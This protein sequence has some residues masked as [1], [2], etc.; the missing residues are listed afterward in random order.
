[1]KQDGEVSKDDKD[2]IK[3]GTSLNTQSH[4][5]GRLQWEKWLDRTAY[6]TQHHMVRPN[7]TSPPHTHTNSHAVSEWCPFLVMSV[8]GNEKWNYC[9]IIGRHRIILQIQITKMLKNKQRWSLYSCIVMSQ[10][11]KLAVVGFSVDSSVVRTAAGHPVTFSGFWHFEHFI[12]SHF[13][14]AG[15]LALTLIALR[16][17]QH[18]HKLTIAAAPSGFRQFTTINK[19]CKEFITQASCSV[20]AGMWRPNCV[21][22]V[23]RLQKLQQQANYTLPSF[24]LR[25]DTCS[26][27]LCFD[28]I[29]L[30]FNDLSTVF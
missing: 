24:F 20:C 1:M 6:M 17:P 25:N 8:G 7:A 3:R 23:W 30:I 19:H 29:K 2:G 27:A 4:V 12:V 11:N 22:C 26:E 28:L 18:Q 13:Y 16:N 10:R 5:M 14:T 21:K 15:P 9:V